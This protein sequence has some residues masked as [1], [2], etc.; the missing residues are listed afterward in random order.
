MVGLADA[1]TAARGQGQE[2]GRRDEPDS[3][4]LDAKCHWQPGPVQSSPAH[5]AHECQSQRG[6]RGGDW[7]S[8]DQAPSSRKWQE[9]QKG[10]SSSPGTSPIGRRHE[11]CFLNLKP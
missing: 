10:A 8:A 5:G 3:V 1:R 6:R 11:E 9:K 4:M 7:H 2:Q